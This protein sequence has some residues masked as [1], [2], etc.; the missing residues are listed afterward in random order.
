M[1]PGSSASNHGNDKI[2]VRS[3]LRA[4]AGRNRRVAWLVLVLGLMITAMATLSI[5]SGVDRIAEHDFVARGDGIHSLIS[6]RL[7][8]HARILQSGAALFG[9]SDQVSR[10]KWQRFN[11][12]Q[13][14]EKQLPGIQGMGYALLIP[15]EKLAG[16]IEEIRSEGFADYQVRPAGD[17]EIYS[18]IIYLEPFADRNLRAFG[19]DMLS[20]PVRRAAMEQ[21]RD[22]DSAALSG[23]VVLVQETDKQ[24]QAGTLMYVP[25]YRNDMP[26]ETVEQRRAAIIGWVYSPYRMTDL[27]NG[28]LGDHNLLEQEAQLLLDIHDGDQPSPTSLLYANHPANDPHRWSGGRFTR[29]IPVDFHGHHWCLVLSQADRGGGTAEYANVWL[30][31]IGGTLIFLLLFSLILVLLNTRTKAQQLADELTVDL[32]RSQESLRQTTERLT[33]ATR[34][35]GVGIWDADIL[36]DTLVWDDQM[37][38]LYGITQDQFGGTYQAWQGG[39]HPDDRQRCDAEIQLALQGGRDFDT[40]FRALWADG[41]IRHIR[42]FAMVQ[43]DSSGQAVRM[44]GTNWDI[45]AQKYAETELARLSVIQRELV[46]LATQFVNV[47]LELQDAAI[48]KSL[49]TMGRLIAADRAYLFAYDFGRDVMSNTHEWC[50]AEITPEIDNLQEVPNG[51]VP[52]WV[53]AHQRGELMLIASVAALPR[54]SN[55]RQMLEPQGIRSLMTLPLM[56]G[57]VC[58]GFVGFDAVRNERIW[59]DEEVA[60]LR[61]LAELYAHFEARRAVERETRELQQR[62]TQ[63]RDAAQS[64]ALAK[65]LFLANMSHEI[66][67]PLNAIL[68]YAQIME[69]E[70]RCCPTGQR[71][72]A[73][74]RSADHLLKLLTDLLELVRNDAHTITLSPVAFDFYQTLDDVRLMFVRHT[75]AQGLALEFSHEAEVPRWIFADSGKVRQILVNLLGNAVKFTSK[76][77]VRLR[78]SAIT[79]DG[80]DAVMI[81]VD[82]CDTGSGIDEHELERIFDVFEQA[83]Q[84]RKSGKGT[85]L[86]LPLSRRYA[87]ALGGNV[88]LTTTSGEGSQFRFTFTARV[89]NGD[90]AVLGHSGSVLRLASNQKPCRVLV[91]DDEPENHEM[92]SAMLT[93]VGFGVE[94]ASTAHQALLRLRQPGTVDLVLMD[95]RLPGLDGY[96]AIGRLRELAGG[97]ELPVLVVTASGFADE[98]DLALAAGA[99]GY[100]AKPVRRELLLAEIG[101][102]AGIR[103]EY[104]QASAPA[105]TILTGGLLAAARASISQQQRL[106]FN[107]AL[108]AGDIRLLR[109][110]IASIDPEHAELAATLGEFA[111]SY[112]YDGLRC[113]FAPQ[114][115]DPL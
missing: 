81:A 65:S 75:E 6:N 5:K 105:T 74:T 72:S 67:T 70:C 45:T 8:E 85:G 42:G 41:T 68:G 20:E 25:V 79:G 21:A 91:V 43:R 80:P 115:D 102:I 82:V 4:S 12:F 61:V 90:D 44:I 37:F 98:K 95:K 31:L 108:H 33:L 19:Y 23:K 53:N 30:T 71:L 64:S 56:Q 50:R 113:L 46:A 62:L 77:G 35:G 39:L 27:L 40:E 114:D 13:K 69:S 16:H 106:L 88:T 28:I 3:G 96:E 14:L 111:N 93:A 60:L 11:Q 97:K 66:R 1:K 101:R 7:N 84:G 89:V 51:M 87:K 104:Q 38:R 29:Q 52:D 54:E 47:P 76:G 86:G 73:I 109:E 99:N 26:T 103:Y 34:A 94:T 100:V 110:M 32:Q 112:D 22:A 83:Q 59:Q 9:V 17:R 48:N 58:L 78:T 63:A 15:R 18:S 55:L 107:R 92:L 2:I 57:D 49:A 10:G 24:V 36:R